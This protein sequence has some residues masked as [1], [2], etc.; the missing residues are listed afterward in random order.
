M[1]SIYLKY[2]YIYPNNE[3]NTFIHVVRIE[4]R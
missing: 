4:N 1:M 3:H 2:I